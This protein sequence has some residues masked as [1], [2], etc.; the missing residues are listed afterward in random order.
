MTDILPLLLFVCLF[1]T[2]LLGFPVAFTLGGI[3]LIFGLLTFGFNFFNLLPLR[4]WG[5]MTNYVLIA[6]PLF[7]YMGVMLEKSGLAEEL[8][9]TMALLFGKLRGGLA[10]SV[11]VVGAMLGAS[12]GIV[13]ATVVTMGL[14]SLPTMLKRGYHPELATGVISASG[15]LGQ[16]IPPSIV[17]VLLGSILNV[18]IGDMFIG[19]VIPG[20]ILVSLYLIWVIIVSILRPESAPA[21][22]EEELAK[23]KGKAMVKRVLQAFVMP[24]FLV[25]AVLGSIFAG[26]ASPTEAAAVGAF[27]ATLLTI[28][29]KRFNYQT[30]KEVMRETSLLTCMVFIILVGATSFGLVFRGMGGDRQLTQFIVS[31]NL[32][33]TTFLALVMVVVFIAGFFIDFI[34]IT[35]IIVPVVAPIFQKLGISLLWIGVL[36][37]MNL[38]T[39]FL[40]PPFGF[41]LFYL[42][43]VA[44]EG[45]RTGQIYRGIIPFVVIQLIG[46][47]ILLLFPE[48]VNWLPR[49]TFD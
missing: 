34:E 15:T 18:S 29:H 12:T 36:I 47:T 48:T 4:I 44:P 5:I 1:A 35:F 49:V 10:I 17:L 24:F 9:E 6:V 2:L 11:I 26:I 39:S 28:L 37:A 23:F 16:I 32:G 13:G 21:M 40:T 33:P 31:A 46:L 38:Q 19:A 3:S 14:L 22:P 7:V 30:L 43:G 42:K 27:G 8:L 20:T 41:S 25:L 45:I